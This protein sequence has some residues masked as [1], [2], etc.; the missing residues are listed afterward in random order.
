MV[1]V[2]ELRT[3]LRSIR[4][5][6]AKNIGYLDFKYLHKMKRAEL[7]NLLKKYEKFE[8]EVVGTIQNAIRNKRSRNVA[9]N[10]L[11][12]REKAQVI[13][14]MELKLAFAEPAALT[15]AISEVGF[16]SARKKASIR[17]LYQPTKPPTP[18]PPTPL[19]RVRTIQEGKVIPLPRSKVTQRPLS[20]SSLQPVQYRNRLQLPQRPSTALP[21]NLNL[22]AV[23]IKPRPESSSRTFNKL[24]PL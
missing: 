6:L 13:R 23:E 18:K 3:R 22:S 10:L 11:K 16:S 8:T 7:E 5:R 21:R 4:A 17:E 20:A 2:S 19:F 24:K 12:D 1:S 14:D 9:E 15:S